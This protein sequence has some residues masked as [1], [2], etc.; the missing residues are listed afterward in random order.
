MFFYQNHRINKELSSGTS[1]LYIAHQNG[2]HIHCVKDGSLLASIHPIHNDQLPTRLPE[3]GN[4]WST[5]PDASAPDG[6]FHTNRPDLITVIDE[7]V[8]GNDPH[9]LT[10][11]DSRRLEYLSTFDRPDQIMKRIHN[12]TR[13]L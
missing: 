8:Q 13:L 6:W 12:E 1:L 4:L 5:P 9:V 7:D 3:F 10:V 2:I 11:D